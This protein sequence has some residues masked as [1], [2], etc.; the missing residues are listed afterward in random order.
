VSITT[1]NIGTGSSV[2]GVATTVITTT[3]AVPA[4]NLIVLCVE[5]GTGSGS[6]GTVTD[7]AGNTWARCTSSSGSSGFGFVAMYYAFNCIALPSG[8]TITYTKQ[9]SSQQAATSAMYATGIE[10]RFNPY[11]DAMSNSAGGGSGTSPS[12]QSKAPTAEAG[13]LFVGSASYNGISPTWTQ[14]SGWSNNPAPNNPLECGSIINSGTGQETYNPTSNNSGTNC[15]GIA[16]FRPL[17][18]PHLAQLAQSG[19]GG[20]PTTQAITTGVAVPAGSLIVVAVVEHNNVIGGSITDT[21]GNTYTRIVAEEF[22]STQEFGAIFYAWNCLA[23][24]ATGTITYTCQSAASARC[25]TA[26]FAVGIVNNNDPHE[27]SVDAMTTGTSTTPSV[28]SG[29]PT[30]ASTLLIGATY[31]SATG[32]GFTLPSGWST[33]APVSNG[34]TLV[35]L[36]LSFEVLTA[37]AATTYNPTLG[38]SVAWGNAVTG[39]KVAA[40]PNLIGNWKPYTQTY[41]RR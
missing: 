21:A 6:G 37:I 33:A 31:I 24:T 35:G 34:G 29:T 26:C 16:A 18:N 40:S 2:A 27:S 19:N 7:S 10:N 8:G 23:L 3:A 12:T 32:I 38:N 25:M 15:I 14:S 11:V 30:Q 17:V 36:Q 13:M 5:E 39:F 41:L 9:N 1:T 28:T 20:G 22:N 4:G